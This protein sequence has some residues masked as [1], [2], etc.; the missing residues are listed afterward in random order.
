MNN[1]RLKSSKFVKILMDSGVINDASISISPEKY[2]REEFNKADANIV[3]TRITNNVK[4][5]G[6]NDHIPNFKPTTHLTP[7]TTDFGRMNFNQFLKALEVVACKIFPTI[8]LDDAYLHL[9]EDY[10]LKLES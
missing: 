5:K 6:I 7:K 8:P 1:K 3:F 2:T 9:I 10:V 4:P